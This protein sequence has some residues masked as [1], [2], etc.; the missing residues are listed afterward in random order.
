MGNNISK[1][2][3]C[4]ICKESFTNSS[5]EMYLDLACSNCNQRCKD[6]YHQKCFQKHLQPTIEDPTPFICPTCIDQN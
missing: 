1:P 5:F 3:F 6:Y 2:T 4:G